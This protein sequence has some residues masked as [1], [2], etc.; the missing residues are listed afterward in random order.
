MKTDSAVEAL[1]RIIAEAGATKPQRDSADVRLID[2]VR[3]GTGTIV[4]TTNAGR[5]VAER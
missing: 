1:Q 4:D 2:Q 3:N 5:G